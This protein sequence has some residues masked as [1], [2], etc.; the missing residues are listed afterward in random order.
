MIVRLLLPALVLALTSCDTVRVRRIGSECDGAG[1]CHVLRTE[2]TD[3][4]GVTD[5]CPDPGPY[6]EQISGG[7]AFTGAQTVCWSTHYSCKKYGVDVPN[8]ECVHATQCRDPTI[9]SN[10]DVSACDDYE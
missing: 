3:A 4:H 8:D 7:C 6:W 1:I 10:R 5:Q 9:S 2:C